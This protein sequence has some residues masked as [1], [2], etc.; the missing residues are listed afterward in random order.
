MSLPRYVA[1]GAGATA[2]HYAFLL[3]AVESQWLP[4]PTATA[5]GALLGALIAYVGN[6]RYTFASERT[7][8]VA[9]PR[10]FLIAMLGAALNGVVVWLGYAQLAWHYFPAQLLATVLVT[11]LT[12]M[13][14]R[15]WTFS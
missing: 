9:A 3:L 11:L 1:V 13:A 14:N 12:Y 6:H 15:R 8:R 4:P 5:V 2:T 7:H 10:F